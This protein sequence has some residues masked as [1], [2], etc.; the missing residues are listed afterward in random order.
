[1][2]QMTPIVKEIGEYTFHIR[3]FPAFV[4]A[5]ICGEL[6]KIATPLLGAITA[7]PTGEKGVGDIE[8]DKAMP[9]L[10]EALSGLSGD[11]FEEL[12]KK[13]LVQ[14]KNISVT[15]PDGKTVM[16][17]MD[18]ANEIF[19]GELQDM[20]VLCFEVIKLNF[21]SFFKK[22]GARFG[23]QIASTEGV[24]TSADGENSI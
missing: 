1:M 24:Q 11:K 6:A 19:C 20:L 5:N 17:D 18:T 23:K 9:I 13:L 12:M 2:K 15:D 7:L 3:P 8:M 22:L 16:L 10:T 4:S 14:Y 21:S